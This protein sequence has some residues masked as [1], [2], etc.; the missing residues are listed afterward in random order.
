MRQALSLTAPLRAEVDSCWNH[1]SDYYVSALLGGASDP[2]CTTEYIYVDE[3]YD[4]G[5]TWTTVWEGD[6]TVCG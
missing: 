6:A 3:S 5:Q 1:P 2:G 4:G